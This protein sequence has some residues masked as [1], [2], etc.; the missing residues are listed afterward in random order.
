M[1]YQIVLSAISSIWD[2]FMSPVLQEREEE[3][4]GE[5]LKGQKE[6]LSD[7]K[8]ESELK[9]LRDYWNDPELDSDE[10]FLK[11]YILNKR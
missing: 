1:Y 7:K 6:E 10:L 2:L 3:D 4:F 8:T 5:W 11:D 9:Y